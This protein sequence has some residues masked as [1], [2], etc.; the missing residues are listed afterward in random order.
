MKKVLSAS[1][2]VTGKN[3][4]KLCENRIDSFNIQVEGLVYLE[5]LCGRPHLIVANHLTPKERLAKK[6]NITPDAFAIS[7]LVRTVN[8]QRL[9]IMQRS[10][11]G[12]W[13]E[14]RLGQYVQKNI[15]WPFAKGF[16][17]G[18]DNIPIKK[19][20]GGF[21]RDFLTEAIK[22]KSNSRPML[23]FPEGCWHNDFDGSDPKHIIHPG[24]A[25]IAQK[26]KLPI[27]PVYIKGAHSWLKSDKII[28][29][30]GQSFMANGM[31]IDAVCSKIKEEITNSKHCLQ[32][33]I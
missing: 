32:L 7:H 28:V 17:I 6:F 12:Y 3:V 31:D 16:V 9:S 23:I 10:D 1:G 22:A 20:P 8:K 33:A 19:N 2:R 29:S 21:N 27:L 30:F 15:F 18:A 13:Y 24:A 11:D 25:H 26:L 5:E 14:S 4:R